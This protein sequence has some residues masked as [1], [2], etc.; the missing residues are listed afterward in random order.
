MSSITIH[1][2]AGSTYVRTTRMACE[3]K[4]IEYE[5]V[6]LDYGS[7]S[8]GE[9]HPFRKMPVLDDGNTHLFEALALTT[10]V[11]ETGNG[12][13]SL[14]PDDPAEKA[15]MLQWVSAVNDYLYGDAVSALL[16][17]GPPSDEVIATA[18][19]RFEQ[20][21]A[22]L[23][24]RDWLAG[25]SLSLADL[26]L[27]PIDAFAEAALEGTGALEGLDNLAAWREK[28]RARPSFAATES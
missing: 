10:Y 1:G 28:V 15:R 12:G 14:Q 3:E 9:L 8:H 17:E 26:F 6:P 7:D 21:D 22:A 16:E 20:F 4:G 25:E 19:N 2:F 27:A 11:D 24:G 13:T 23:A 5:L 18:R